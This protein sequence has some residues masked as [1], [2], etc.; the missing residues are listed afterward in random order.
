MSKNILITGGTGFIGSH[1]TDL[2]LENGY[3]VSVLSRSARQSN[4]QITYY[5]WDLKKNFIEE[6]AILNADFIIHLAGEGIV[7][8]RWTKKRKKAIIDSRVKPIEL[9][10]SVL[11]KHNKSLEGFISASGIGIYGAKTSHKICNEETP[12][13]NDFLGMTCQI[14][15]NAVDKIGSLNIR[16]AKIRTG[17]VLAKDQGFMKKMTPTFKSGF[18]AVL[19]TGKQY[20]PWI[21]V[22]DLCR[23]Y[24]KAIEDQE[25]IGPYNACITDNTTNSRL[26][27]LLAELYG[28]NI[29]LPKIPTFF[30]K[31]LLGEMSIAVL[32][33]QRVSSDK[34]QKTGFEFLFTDLEKTLINCVK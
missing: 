7:E 31:L 4:S 28:Y 22:D 5:Q 6:D 8:K 9:I 29:W 26:S 18:G 19:G 12:P 34:I 14:W 33:G 32:K 3:S 15:E 21:Y 24:L 23:I 27:R 10:L 16:T 25:V 30:L 11:T 20:I 13:A 1:L 17:I 2:L